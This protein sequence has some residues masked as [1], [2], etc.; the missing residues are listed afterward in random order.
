MGTDKQGSRVILI[1]EGFM[2]EAVCELRSN[3]FQ[4]VLL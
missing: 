2:E 4:K 3:G 1:Q